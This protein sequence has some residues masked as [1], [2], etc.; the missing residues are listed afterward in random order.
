M[1]H[2]QLAPERRKAGTTG[3]TAARALPHTLRNIQVSDKGEVRL[4]TANA[5]TKG[6]G[7]DQRAST[8]AA[9]QRY[10]LTQ[11]HD[12]S[13]FL[14]AHTNTSSRAA[15]AAATRAATETTAQYR[16]SRG[17]LETQE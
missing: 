3:S 14:L 1:H 13:V 5:Q 2:R 12:L 9:H 16:K 15:T 17:R 4:C 10:G 8:D 6:G 7:V 11:G